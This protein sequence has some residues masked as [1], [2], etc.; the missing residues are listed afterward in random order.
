[1]LDIFRINTTTVIYF[2]LHISFAKIH[3]DSEIVLSMTL[4]FGRIFSLMK[5]FH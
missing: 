2:V 5:R 4:L 3:N 1:M